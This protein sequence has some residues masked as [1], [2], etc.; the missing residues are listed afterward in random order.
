MMEFGTENFKRLRKVMLHNPK[1]SLRLINEKNYAKYLF[2]GVPNIDKFCKEHED[3]KRLLEEQGIKTFELSN[4]VRINK[5]LLSRL[6]NLAF[7]HD[8]AVVISKGAVISNMAF[9]GRKN[10]DIVVKEALANMRIPIFAEFEEDEIFEGFLPLSKRI[11]LVANTER[12]NDLGINRFYGRV[13]TFFEEIISVQ[14]PQE[15][16]F[17]HLDTIFGSVKKD[18]ALV[19]LPAFQHTEIIKKDGKCVVDF[20]EY[21]NEKGIE[22]INITSD[23]QRNW[24]CTFLPLEPG[25]IFHYDIAL[26]SKTKSIL[27]R[28]NVEIIEFSPQ[29]LLPGGGSLRC[30]TLQILRK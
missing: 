19:Y 6:P 1:E 24:G 20:E 12:Y 10:E 23:E 2:D 25:V 4:F 28:K 11:A 29:A 26:N 14:V 7:M 15:R 3:Y 27:R 30:L 18:L 17:M 21:M 13:L 16:R 8:I 22:L 5:D 9:W